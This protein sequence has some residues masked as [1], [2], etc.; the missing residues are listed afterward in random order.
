MFITNI[1]YFNRGIR[2]KKRNGLGSTTL[3]KCDLKEA[4]TDKLRWPYSTLNVRCQSINQSSICIRLL[5]ICV[6]SEAMDGRLSFTA[7]G[8]QRARLSIPPTATLPSCL[9][10]LRVFPSFHGSRLEILYRDAS[11]ATITIF[12]NS[13]TNFT[14]AFRYHGSL[15]KNPCSDKNRT[16]DFRTTSGGQLLNNGLVNN[17]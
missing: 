6:F 17:S 16:H 15:N 5:G 2:H 10:S 1:L 11:S 8:P 12:L 7:D 4:I 14:H 3:F 9:W 13:S